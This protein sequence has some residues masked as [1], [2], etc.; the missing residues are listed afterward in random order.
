M[1]SARLFLSYV[2]RYRCPCSQR[3]CSDRK[4]C[5]PWSH[6]VMHIRITFA[7]KLTRLRYD[8]IVR[9]SHRHS[10]SELASGSRRLCDRLKFEEEEVFQ[11]AMMDALVNEGWVMERGWV[12]ER[13][14]GGRWDIQ[15]RGLRCELRGCTQTFR[16]WGKRLGICNSICHCGSLLIL[17]HLAISNAV[18]TVLSASYY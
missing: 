5:T 3:I 10:S 1:C 9:M 6:F 11:V 2:P 13:G 12:T 8:T 14:W 18:S 16:T 17:R 15:D 4:Y 7:Y